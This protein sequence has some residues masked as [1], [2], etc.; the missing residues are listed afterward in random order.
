MSGNDNYA[1]V[2]LY[3]LV[4][5]RQ[6]TLAV[7]FVCKREYDSACDRGL[8]CKFFISVIFG[9]FIYTQ[10]RAPKKGCGHKKTQN[11]KKKTNIICNLYVVT[12]KCSAIV[13]V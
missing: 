7:S 1:K 11:A 3:A 13:V 2:H 8:L 12:F 6:T 9:V 10:K 4:T 5:D